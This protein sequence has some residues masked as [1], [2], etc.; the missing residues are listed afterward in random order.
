MDEITHDDAEEKDDDVNDQVTC[1]IFPQGRVDHE[2]QHFQTAEH[3][4]DDQPIPTEGRF[5]VGDQEELE[6]Q[7][8]TQQVDDYDN[9]GRPDGDL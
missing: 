7:E 5:R 6:G 2:K 8:D 4:F 3:G 1:P 9:D